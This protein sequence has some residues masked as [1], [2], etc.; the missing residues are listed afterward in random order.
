MLLVANSLSQVRTDFH[1]LQYGN[2]QHK[3][4]TPVSAGILSNFL[5]LSSNLFDSGNTGTMTSASART[6]DL[7]SI[8][9]SSCSQRRRGLPPRSGN[10]WLGDGPD[11]A[12]IRKLA[13]EGTESPLRSNSSSNCSRRADGVKTRPIVSDLSIG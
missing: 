12:P 5:N 4:D 10:Q 1:Q 8:P 2:T 7:L 11:Q 9:R 3:A 6:T 13:Y